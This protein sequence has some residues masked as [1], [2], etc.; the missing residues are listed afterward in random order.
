MTGPGQN[1]GVDQITVGFIQSLT[2][3][4]AVAKYANGKTLTF[5][6]STSLP[7]NAGFYPLLDTS[8][9]DMPWYS[10]TD[11]PPPLLVGKSG[12]ISSFDSPALSVYLRYSEHA[13]NGGEADRIASVMML[14]NFTLDVAAFVNTPDP[15]NQVYTR[16]ATKKWSYNVNETFDRS[17]DLLPGGINSVTVPNQGSWDQ[18]PAGSPTTESSDLVNS[19]ITA[20]VYAALFGDWE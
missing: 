3:F 19:Q 2:N 10:P 7:A 20:N 13:A 5:S 11:T 1:W 18:I 17:Y 4:Q 12:T 14:W 6:T 9:S 15:I 8:S 16:V